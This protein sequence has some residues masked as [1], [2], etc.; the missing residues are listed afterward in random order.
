MLPALAVSA[1]LFAAGCSPSGSEASASATAAPPSNGPAGQLHASANGAVLDITQAV[2]HLDAKG[3]GTL[4]MTVRNSGSVTD[5]LD[6]VSVPGGSRGV[7]TG[8]KGD[9]SGEMTSAGIQ[10]LPGTSV[11]FG[12]GS[13]DPSVQLRAAHATGKHTLP[14]ILQFGVAGLLRIQAMAPAAH[15]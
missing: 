12:T 7:I 2:A 15:S 1:A 8:G 13:G 6:F 9:G 5:H 4:S 14:L 11:T 3:D 10:F